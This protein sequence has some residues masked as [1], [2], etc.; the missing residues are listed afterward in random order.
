MATRRL[1]ISNLYQGTSNQHPA[2]RAPGQIERALNIRLDIGNGATRRNGTDLLATPALSPLKEWRFISFKGRYLV[3]ITNDAVR[4]FDTTDGSEKTVINSVGDF[5]Y[6]N[7]ATERYDIRTAALL[8]TLVILNRKVETAFQASSTYPVLG[9]VETFDKLLEAPEDG[10]GDNPLAAPDGSHYEVLEDWKETRAGYYRKGRN[11]AGAVTWFIVPPPQDDN[12]VPVAETLP[13]RLVHDVDADTF[14][15]EVCPWRSRLSGNDATNP[16]PSWAGSTID[17]IAAHQGR[18]FLIG[19][20][21]ITAG[22]AVAPRRSAFNLYDYNVDQA[23]DIDRIDYSITDSST[24]PCFYADSV[25][26]DLVLACENGIVVYTSGAD[27]LTAFNG[28][29]FLIAN[30]PVNGEV[31]PGVDAGNYFVLDSNRRIHWFIYAEGIRPQGE[32]NDHRPEILEGEEVVD[33][34]TINQTLFVLTD[35][36][37]VKVHERY[38]RPEG[39]LLSAWSELGFYESPVFVGNYN[40][41]VKLL[42]KQVF[43]GFTLLN[44][45]HRQPFYAEGFDYE[46]C[47]DRRETVTGVY[48]G[49]NNRTWFAHSGRLADLESSLVVITTEKNGDRT[50]QPLDPIEVE[51][52]RFYVRGDYRGEHLIGFAYDS[53]VE[54]SALW[55]GASDAMPL[56]SQVNVGHKEATDY[57]FEATE[58]GETSVES[59]WTSSRFG[60]TAFGKIEP[61][62]GISQHLVLGDARY[63]TLGI[64]SRSAGY[65]MIPFVEYKVRARSIN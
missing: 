5:S 62:T 61:E 60:V 49:S 54:L 11:D 64:R 2:K 33:L 32:L 24:G 55:A 51:Q 23:S 38:V 20:S 17:A 56:L 15:F 37:T 41:K 63:T 21:Y 8:D 22:E 46:V 43:N 6:L 65:F 28:R 48:D 47:L 3:A 1:E 19:D 26:A 59:P 31:R 29:D 16:A 4:V 9:V 18:F 39:N 50:N 42:T 45:E 57:I 36:G 58:E 53:L 35:E 52:D 7:G 12:A 10:T 40:D 30:V 13:H 44:Y 14:T 27:A 25:G 34:F